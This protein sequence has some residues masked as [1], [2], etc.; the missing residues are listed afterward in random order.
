MVA[1]M[2]IMIYPFLY[3]IFAS[4][5]IP[6]Q[7]MANQSV[8]LLHPLG[9]TLE[10]YKIVLQY[11]ML[12]SGLKNTLIIMAVRVPISL[13]LTLTGAYCISRKNTMFGKVVAVMGI[14]SMYCS[15]GMIPI[16]LN[17]RDLGLYNSLWSLILPMV[18]STYHILI[19]RSS[20]AGIPDSLEES[21]RIDGAGHLTV[22]FKIITPLIVPTLM[23]VILYLV[24][25]I[26]NSWFEASIFLQDLSKIPLQLV[27]RS[28]LIQNN[29][30]GM[31]SGL[32]GDTAGI[33]ETLQYALMVLTTLPILC[34]YP[35]LQKY[36]V[37][38]V[39]IGAVKG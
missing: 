38:G 6:S 3:V 7:L 13:F 34:V 12:L 9:F 29:T 25:D 18:V 37:K 39:M 11:P 31:T 36:F 14:I 2:I 22:L 17:V 8:F 10:S 26:W 19:V 1:L 33:G 20:M 5:S 16:Y 21:A 23:V 28:I 27:M 15:G 24:V 32:A 35:F 4:L 30:Q